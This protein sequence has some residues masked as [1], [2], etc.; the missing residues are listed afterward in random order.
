VC[1]CVEFLPT[2]GAC[3]EE[4]SYRLRC[5]TSWTSVVGHLNH[6]PVGSS[7]GKDIG[8]SPPNLAHRREEPTRSLTQSWNN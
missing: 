5:N 7:L 8:S 2:L 6:T 1:T 3:V 4:R